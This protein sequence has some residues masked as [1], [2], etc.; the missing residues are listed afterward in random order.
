MAKKSKGRMLPPGFTLRC[1]LA[2]HFGA[3][4]AVTWS[5]DGSKIATASHDE[6][7]KIWNAHD[8]TVLRTIQGHTSRITA[9]AWSRDET[10]LASGSHRV[11]VNR[12]NS[13]EWLH[14]LPDPTGPINSLSWSPDGRILAVGGQSRI[15]LWDAQ[16]GILIRTI[17]GS[18]GP[19]FALAWSPDSR[20]L[21]SSL[22]SNICIWESS[23]GNLLRR[24][25]GHTGFVWSLAWSSDGQ[26][27]ASGSQDQTISLWDTKK[28]R[29]IGVLEGHTESVKRLFFSP[30]STILASEG[31]SEIR[32]WNSES[33][34]NLSVL[35]TEKANSLDLGLSFSPR[36]STLTSLDNGGRVI[37]VWD[38]DP[39]HILG[40]VPINSPVRYTNA[41]VVL[42]GDTGV[43]KSG[44][45]IV[46]T[47]SQF[48]PTE[49]THGRRVWTLE[50]QN[51]ILE[52]GRAETREILLW[53]MA[54]Q[55]GYR[56]VHQL[57][58]NEIA[59]ALIVFDARSETDPFAGVRHWER[60]L[61]QAQKIQEGAA[62]PM[63]K[64]LVA[65]RIDRGGV[66]VSR[67]RIELLMKDV[68]ID[69]FFE[70]SAKEGTQIQE[71][72]A[73]I[74]SV[75]HWPSLPRVSSTELFQRIKQFLIDEKK[76]GRL[77]SVADDLY[78]AFLASAKDIDESPNLR[79]QF[80][81]CIG[82]VEARDLIK[83]LSFGNLILLQPEILDAYASAM[84]HAAKDEPDG[85]GCIAEEDALSGHFT[86]P[87][88]ERLTDSSMEKL[89]LIATVESLLRHEIAL[90]ETSEEG[91]Q[92]VFPSQ[93][94]RENPDIPDP[95][96]KT[97]VIT[98]EGP[99]VAIYSTLAVRLS[100]SGLFQT[101]EMWKNAVI[102]E[103]KANGL[104]GMV[105][106]EVEEGKGEIA[107]FHDHAASRDTR[108]HFEEYIYIHLRRWAIPQSIKIKRIVVCPS[109]NLV[110]TPQF[111]RMKRARGFSSTA[112][113]ICEANVSLLSEEELP[114]EIPPS[115]VSEMDQEAD[116]KRDLEAAA[117]I[118]E[119]KRVT[120][121][122]DVFLCHNSHDKP[123]V[124]QIATQLRE[125]GILPW[126]DV[127]ELRPGS[128]WQR[129]LENQIGQIKCAAVFVGKS[130]L[131]PWQDREQEAF[132][133]QF[134]K[135]NSPVIPVVLPDCKE[136]PKLPVFL[137]GLHWVDF[138]KQN[139]DPFDQLIWGITGARP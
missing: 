103:A 24:L 27:L 122:F 121:D 55:P 11:R 99:V 18:S 12:A 108:F 54:G 17:P 19:A 3:I 36:G 72:G 57:H 74:R 23:N 115:A 10:L 39:K 1:T 43:G 40:S 124:Q 97:T 49:S 5:A 30:D 93:F 86:V 105:I 76:A 133:S 131:G 6:E 89:L 134:V 81:T 114:T 61:R 95:E 38:L 132:I 106:R 48:R 139:P 82:R 4:S 16:R 60:A 65:A 112:C 136:S 77:L 25:T 75:I 135:R 29:Q 15:N 104:C 21:V 66:G 35:R 34:E 73:R 84:V 98:F 33:W 138:R 113:P 44:L 111:I 90:K 88:D 130:G 52:S 2:K 47:E 83:R 94:T 32:I 31:F 64:L 110:L 50:T 85:L 125:R 37:K 119:G 71:L 41:K 78:R 26:F 87:S 79:S 80:E 28:W 62:P 127:W 101:K 107:L 59:V 117:A 53:D 14:T 63:T 91:T 137:E 102:F 22:N 13:G 9:L 46:L 116:A 45:G 70:T 123:F 69:Y 8:G 100:R 126:F 42:V 118:I 58:L 20:V 7:I 96:G 68:G 128:R 92:L 67:K 51:V 120:Q 56:L 129:E 109:C